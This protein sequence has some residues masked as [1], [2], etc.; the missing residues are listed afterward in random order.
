MHDIAVHVP[1]QSRSTIF[2]PQ[3]VEP[4]ICEKGNLKT[5]DETTLAEIRKI[6]GKSEVSREERVRM[7]EF[8]RTSVELS[9][10]NAGNFIFI[11]THTRETGHVVKHF[12]INPEAVSGIVTNKLYNLSPTKLHYAEEKILELACSELNCYS[13]VEDFQNVKPVPNT[14]VVDVFARQGGQLKVNPRTTL[15][16]LD[17]T[18]LWKKGENEIVLID[19]TTSRF[20][21][22]IAKSLNSR[23]STL[24]FT[25]DPAGTRYPSQE[26]RRVHHSVINIALEI[27]QQHYSGTNT[28]DILSNVFEKVFGEKTLGRKATPYK[29]LTYETFKKRS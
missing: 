8:S 24:T 29:E 26:R 27:D 6:I 15:P 22:H 21:Q 2:T 11:R 5:F 23:F 14:V 10:I 7:M 4:I 19:P 18:V 3:L 16:E 12:S 9:H 28:S 1:D 25:V 13:S 17:T 20:S